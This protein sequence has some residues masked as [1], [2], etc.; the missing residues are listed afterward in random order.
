M[1]F[2]RLISKLALLSIL[3]IC[4]C[5]TPINATSLAE[6]MKNPPY[7]N[8]S[9]EEE[10]QCYSLPYGAIG[11]LS[12]I[13]TYYT[14]GVLSAQRHP[15]APWKRNKRNGLDIWLAL[16]GL[17][18]TIIISALTMVR[19]R[20]RWQFIAIAAW[21]LD[22]SVTF[23]CLSLHAACIIPSRDKY[24]YMGVANQIEGRSDS[25]KILFWL[26]LYI[27]GVS[28][29][30]AGLLSLVAKTI[31]TNHDV[32]II[33]AV[34]GSVT[35]AMAVVVGLFVCCFGVLGAFY[36][37]WIL[38]AIAKNMTGTPTTDNAVFYWVYFVAKRLPFFSS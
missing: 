1:S 5:P 21:K 24:K 10:I 18:G 28:A 38:A 12:H 20:S 9:L 30:M 27:P 8:G 25:E 15:W 34:F 16:I 37:D 3:V 32:M 7:S 33:T 36:S 4:N 31:N 17:V 13:L 14:I 35:L 22:L 2:F 23:G 11:F 26:L 6:W 19:C 29:G